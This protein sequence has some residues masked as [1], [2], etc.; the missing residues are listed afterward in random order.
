[1]ERSR[2]EILL[3]AISDRQRIAFGGDMEPIVFTQENA[4]RHGKILVGHFRARCGCLMRQAGEH[5]RV[6]LCV[7]HTSA[8]EVVDVRDWTHRFPPEI[9]N[10][11][12]RINHVLENEPGTLVKSIVPLPNSYGT[13][14]L[15][16]SPVLRKDI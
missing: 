7:A 4:D 2:N 15:F 8:G 9:T 14:V 16:Q 12:E 1:M 10:L 5:W 13:L 6:Y 11:D 3:A